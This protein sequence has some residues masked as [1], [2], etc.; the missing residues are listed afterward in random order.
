MPPFGFALFFVKGS[1]PA[2][3]RMADVYKGIVPFVAIQLLVI[4]CVAAFPQ[5][6]TWLLDQFLNLEAPRTF[7]GH[8]LTG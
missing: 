8:G 3:E 5:I 6:A 4:A 1:A 2:G 7:K